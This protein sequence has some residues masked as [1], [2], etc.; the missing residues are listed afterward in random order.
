MFVFLISFGPQFD[1]TSKL[2]RDYKNVE[3]A[4]IENSKV[5][6]SRVSFIIE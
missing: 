1:L 2:T 4:I 3:T 5:Q 6:L